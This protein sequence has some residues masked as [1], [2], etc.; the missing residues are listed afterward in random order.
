MW[1]LVFLVRVRALEPSSRAGGREAA[2]GRGHRGRAA[3]RVQRAR[4]RD[5]AH[6]RAQHARCGEGR[7]ENTA[8]TKGHNVFLFLT[9][10]NSA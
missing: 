4:R 8:E 5:A 9:M 10:L 6:P 7:M 2:R 1:H 3:A